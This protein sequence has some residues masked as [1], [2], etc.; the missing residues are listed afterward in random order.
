MGWNPEKCFH[1]NSGGRKTLSAAWGEKAT[2]KLATF[3]WQ[4]SHQT[5]HCSIRTEEN[6][7][8]RA[9]FWAL[10]RKFKPLMTSGGSKRHGKDIRWRQKSKRTRVPWT[11][12]VQRRG[13]SSKW[14]FHLHAS[15]ADYIWSK[16]N[17]RKHHLRHGT[18]RVCPFICLPWTVELATPSGCLEDVSRG[19][20][21]C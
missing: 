3:A 2:L 14:S 10:Q 18:L 1:F 17:Y 4:Q 9:L 12:T 15:A 11:K 19:R 16:A 6:T 7:F 21:E 20:D 5:N 8:D 13:S